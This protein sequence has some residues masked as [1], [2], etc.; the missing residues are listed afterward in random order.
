M[1]IILLFASLFQLHF[2]A[3][4]TAETLISMPEKQGRWRKQNGGSVA[5][6]LAT[7]FLTWR[8]S[9]GLEPC[10]AFFHPRPHWQDWMRDD[11]NSTRCVEGKL[12]AFQR[13][14][15]QWNSIHAYNAVHVVRLPGAPDLERLKNSILGTLVDNG[16]TGF[17][18]NRNRGTFCYRGGTATSEICDLNNEEATPEFLAGEIERQLNT[19]FPADGALSPFRFFVARSP[20]SFVFGLTYLHAVADAQSIVLLLKNIAERYA[21]QAVGQTEV[22]VLR[23]ASP[24]NALWSN[25]GAFLSKLAGLPRFIAEM[26]R[27]FRPFFHDAKDQHNRFLLVTLNRADLLR[28]MRTAKAWGVTVNDLLLALLLKSCEPHSFFRDKAKT[29]TKMSVGCIVNT[30]NDFEPEAAAGFGLFLGSFAITHPMPPDIPVAQ[31]ARDVAKMTRRI[32]RKKLYLATPLELTVGRL[33]LSLFPMELQKRLYQKHYPL[34]GGV[35]NM[36]INALWRTGEKTGPLDYLRGVSTGP[37]T[38]LVLSFTTIGEIANVG[39]SYRTT[40][41]SED[42]IQEFVRCFRKLVAELEVRD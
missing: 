33:M 41:F 32:K 10:A 29:R 22:P 24:P 18:L 39:L 17:E 5:F 25:P 16:L 7:L 27:C 42:A 28:L 31:L 11:S 1:G 3:S 38:P 19:P 6:L 21:G 35:T 12:S 2:H 15:L 36:N 20:G 9:F 34:W 30:R 13:A 23:P 14:M 40:V 8:G 37:A 26:R 4:A